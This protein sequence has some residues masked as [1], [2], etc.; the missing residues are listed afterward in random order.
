MVCKLKKQSI[1]IINQNLKDKNEATD[2]SINSL[3]KDQKFY[4]DYFQR[5][6]R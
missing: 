3:L 1:N 6:Y 5:E 2:T 4:I